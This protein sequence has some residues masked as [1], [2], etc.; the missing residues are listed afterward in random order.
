VLCLPPRIGEGHPLWQ[1]KVFPQV[2]EQR[3]INV[4]KDVGGRAFLQHDLVQPCPVGP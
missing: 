4:G 1:D 2:N 3:A